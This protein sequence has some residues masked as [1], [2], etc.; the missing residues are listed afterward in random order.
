MNEKYLLALDGGTGSFR[1]ILFNTLGEQIAINQKDWRHKSNPLYP[2][3][4]DFDFLNNWELIANCIKELIEKSCINAEQIIGI[5]TTSMR[6]GFILYDEVGNE[7][8][9]FSNVDARATKEAE[10]L[11]TNFPELEHE[12][13]LETGETFALSAIPRLLWVKDHLPDIYSKVSC[14]TM[15]NDWISYKLTGVLSSE[16]SNASTSG[17]FGLEN[18]NWLTSIAKKFNLKE[19]IF[20]KVFESGSLISNV[21]ELAALKT[22]LSTKTKV[23][24]GGGDAQLGCIGIGATQTGQAALLG[25]SFWQLEY[26]TSNPIVDNNAK[27]RANCH[28][29]P[30]VWQLEAIAWCPGLVMKWF[31]EGFCHFENELAIQKKISVYKILDEKAQ[32]VPPGCFGLIS[33]FSNTMDFKNLKHVS[34]TITNFQLDSKKFN[35][36][37][38]YRSIMENAGLV[39]YSH[40][41]LIQD[42]TD[43]IIEEIIFAGG[44]SYSDLWCQIICN[45][46]GVKLTIPVEKEATALGAALLA[47]VGSGVYK[48][49]EETKQLI[50]LEKTFFPDESEHNLYK[51]IYCR[52]KEAYPEYLAIAD[53]GLVDHMWIA[54]GVK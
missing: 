39:T 17:L 23:I 38:F 27:I 31:K 53:K 15:I 36:Y 41:L 47:G 9:A 34:P 18:R 26:N 1:A 5:S 45:I 49:I 28:A 20:P 37:S 51:E 4:I 25:G 52:W 40:L 21:N 3:S 16:P 44:S 42:L 13:F 12:L 14:I 32:H 19:N 24:A 33:L 10:F 11:K 50:K 46:L 43:E 22:G 29:V 6:E 54:P 35:T 7:L 30:R 48:N 8:I 2:G